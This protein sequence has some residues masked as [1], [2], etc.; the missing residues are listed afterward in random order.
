MPNQEM[1][2]DKLHRN[3]Q[4][5]FPSESSGA[6]DL[7]G[8]ANI[9]FPEKF[10]RCIHTFGGDGDWYYHGDS[11][12]PSENYKELAKL[13]GT[14]ASHI[15]RSAETHTANVTAVSADFGG[16]GVVRK[17]RLDDVDGLIT[18]EI[19]LVLCMIQSDCPIVYLFNPVRRVV[20]LIHSGR[21]GTEQNIVGKA[22]KLMAEKYGVA[23][24]NIEA[25]I[26]PHICKDCYFTDE[27][28]A[29]AFMSVFPQEQRQKVAAEKDG[30]WTLDLSTAI[31]LELVDA[32][33]HDFNI[34]AS[35]ICTKEQENLF[36]YRRGDGVK[37]N[38]ACIMLEDI[39]DD[40]R[41]WRQYDYRYNQEQ[42]WPESEFP[43]TTYRYLR[44][45]GCFITSL[46]IMMR[47]F[48]IEKEDKFER[49][50]PWIFFK[51]TKEAGFFNTAA[52]FD[53]Y[54][55]SEMYPIE[56]VGDIP[57]S[58][59]KLIECIEKGYACMVSVPGIHGIYHY[60]VPEKITD[61]DVKIIDCGWDCEYLSEFSEVCDIVLFRKKGEN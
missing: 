17:S 23:P 9:L 40:Y 21:R 25:F 46:A 14:D 2:S 51:R 4:F 31:K 26:G 42:A 22:V 37:S 18:D 5:V 43:D 36:S 15:V 20:G 48:G 13:F 1:T 52:E 49:F 50:N 53:P 57:Y 58:R 11:S 60:M 6:D 47:H 29:K 12:N 33:L 10:A 7:F 59:E 61:C 24:R 19:G 3:A 55:I 27:E 16:D 44:D 32:G 41:S 38:L 45:V 54:R 39:N 34:A 35:D 30:K 56:Y 8:Y 28:T